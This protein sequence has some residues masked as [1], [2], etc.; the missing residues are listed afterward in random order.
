MFKTVAEEHNELYHYTTAAGLEGI[1][2]TQQLRATNIAY[3][4]DSEEHTGFFDRRLPSLLDNTMRQIITDVKKEPDGH[5]R[6]EAS[7]GEENALAEAEKLLTWIRDETLEF[8]T[9]YTASFCLP[10]KTSDNGLLS[11]WRG[12]GVDGGYA[13]VFETKGLEQLLDLEAK[14]F[15]YQK[16]SWGD[17]EYYDEDSPQK[18]KHP[19]TI[20]QESIVRGVLHQLILNGENKAIDELYNAITWLSCAHKHD[21]FAE[22][23][24]V[25]IVAVPANDLIHEQAVKQGEIRPRKPIHVAMN[26]GTPVPHIMLFESAM[27]AS[28]QKLPIKKIIVGPHPNRIN[29]R[30]AVEILLKQLG[31]DANVVESD[32]PYVGR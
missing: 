32:I 26:S 21:G 3:L 22:E 29:R 30:K 1:L 4:N 31:V 9:P 15:H 8:N 20:E 11:Q 27:Q 10:S 25:R 16:L 2:R 5:A 18:A 24:E 7:G 23:K 17:V 12:Y 19:E 14:G 13:I 28:P 6:I